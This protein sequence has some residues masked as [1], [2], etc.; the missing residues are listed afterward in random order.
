MG[1]ENMTASPSGAFRTAD[2]LLNIAANKQKQF[3]ALAGVIG[4]DD[5]ITDVRFALRQA[6]LDHRV[7]LKAEIEAALA[8]HPAEYWWPLL[9]QAGVP[10]VRCTP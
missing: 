5:L 7:E 1:N 10:P 8:A 3:E 2:G 6:R 9:T 4:R